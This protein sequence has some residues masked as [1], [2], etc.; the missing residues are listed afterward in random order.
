MPS[1]RAVAARSTSR[2]TAAE[3][4]L[5]GLEE[6]L[7]LEANLQ[8]ARQRVATTRR[9]AEQLEESSKQA[10]AQWRAALRRLNLPEDMS[11]QAVKQLAE[12]TQQTMH[13]RRQL[14]IRREEYEARER[15]L[16]TLVTRVNQLVEQVQLN[17][18]SPDPQVQLQRLSAALAEQQTLFDR[19][20][21]LRQ[22]DRQTRRQIRKLTQE[23]QK[24]RAERRSI[25][26]AAGARSEQEL[27]QL[28]EKLAHRRGLQ[29]ELRDVSNQYTLA[30][31]KNCPLARVEQEL[32]AHSEAELESLRS[33]LARQTDE[34]R[35]QLAH[36]HQRHGALEQQ[37]H[38]LVADRRRP[39]LLVQLGCVDQQLD[40]AVHR[41]RVLSVATRVLELVR[42]IYETQRQPQT[43]QD[44]SRYFA[45][46]TEGQYVR[47]W[48]PLTDMSLR[49]DLA[50]GESLPLD[51]LSSGTREAVFLSLRLALVADF[52]RR[53]I[54][55]PLILD[56]VLVNF[57]RLRA[58]TPRR[59]CWTS[60]IAGIRS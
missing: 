15:E 46:L 35:Q 48:T 25:M 41:W 11:P 30:L 54:V 4:D 49:V 22:E 40:E 19:R 44:A 29:E 23:L 59:C 36:I 7:P 38:G 32:V 5:A 52:S 58:E 16:K 6:L 34:V 27:R 42:E 50:T 20:Q 37:S 43:L 57:D 60:P 3:Q 17:Y 56:D 53:G 12:G 26:A 33:N 14:D 8:A 2:L 13:S 18:S 28:L 1:C 24:S 39:E 21:Q 10:R 9:R 51:V 31:G 45:A 47:I 55:L